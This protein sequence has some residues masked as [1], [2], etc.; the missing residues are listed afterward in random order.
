MTQIPK[1]GCLG[2][3]QIILDL[4][5]FKDYES[6]AHY[7]KASEIIETKIRIPC[8]NKFLNRY[9]EEIKWQK[10]CDMTW[11][12]DGGNATTSGGGRFGLRTLQGDHASPPSSS[13]NRSTIFASG[14]N[15]IPLRICTKSVILAK[16]WLMP[17]R[18]ICNFCI[19]Q[20]NMLSETSDDNLT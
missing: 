16:R 14:C 1:F 5:E 13:N 12:R 19:E 2:S 4:L 3:I 11:R 17:T 6:Q 15:A 10:P 20:I 9:M 8:I 18:N 7:G